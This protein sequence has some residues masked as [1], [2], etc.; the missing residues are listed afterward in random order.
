M[1]IG[2]IGSWYDMIWYDILW[3]KK[4][5]WKRKKKSEETLENKERKYHQYYSFLIY[6]YDDSYTFILLSFT[7]FGSPLFSTFINYHDHNTNR[8]VRKSISDIVYQYNKNNN[9]ESVVLYCFIELCCM[10]RMSIL[11]YIVMI[12]VSLVFFFVFLCFILLD[13]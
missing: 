9:I 4:E 8:Q 1:E 11:C 7:S 6:F 5:K 3:W 12:L 10:E 2:M 13:I